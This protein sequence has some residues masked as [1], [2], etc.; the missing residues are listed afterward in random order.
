[1]GFRRGGLTTI[2]WI[3]GVSLLD[4]RKVGFVYWEDYDGFRLDDVVCVKLINYA[5]NGWHHLPTIVGQVGFLP[6]IVR[7]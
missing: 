6:G 5:V 4:A 1:M 3:L 2:F 7:Q